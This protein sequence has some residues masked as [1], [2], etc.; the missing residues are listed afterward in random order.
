ME[1]TLREGIDWVGYVDWTLRDF[2]SYETAH[3]VTY[4]AYLIQDEKTALIDAVKEPFSGDLLHKVSQ[5][6]DLAKV[7]YVVCNHAEPDHA[8]GLPAVMAAMPNAK[9]VCN[10][11]CVPAL[12]RYFDTSSWEFEVVETG[13]RIPLGKRTL[14]FIDTPL[15]HWPESMFTYVPEE[16]IL[17][18]MDA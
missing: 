11:R 8:G 1:T 6:T 14:E 2:H 15:V 12:G 7:D 16:K 18:S 4:N 3:G 13:S 5:H 17:F 10:K 9:L